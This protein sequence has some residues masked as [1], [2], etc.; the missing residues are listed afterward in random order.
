MHQQQFAIRKIA[1]ITGRIVGI[2]AILFITAT[3]VMESSR[4]QTFLTKRIIGI[5]EN[6]LDADISVRSVSIKPIKAFVIED[7]VVTDRHPW[8]DSTGNGYAPVDTILAADLIS[9]SFSIRSLFHH[10]G[11]DFSRV[12]I[13]GATFHMVSEPGEIWTGN[14]Q[15]ILRSKPAPE[16]PE[17]G[18]E[19]F[20]IRRLRG[21]DIRFR[22]T[23]M[24]PSGINSGTLGEWIN[25][26]CLDFRISKLEARKVGMRGGR[27]YIIT[28]SLSFSERSGYSAGNLSF[29]GHFGMGEMLFRNVHLTDLWSDV[30]VPEI[31]MSFSNSYS[32][33]D[34]NDKVHMSAHA[35]RTLLSC[36]TLSYFVPAVPY[37][38]AAADILSL[39][40]NGCVNDFTVD[41][42]KFKE[43]ASGTE[44]NLDSRIKNLT[45]P[46]EMFIDADI[47][48]I[49][50]STEGISSL[51]K[52]IS[53]ES[54]FDIG[55]FAPGEEMTFTGKGRG[56]VRKLQTEGTIA[57]RNGTFSTKLYLQNLLD[58]T[59][60]TELAG[61]VSTDDFDLGRILD[62]ELFAGLTSKAGIHASLVPGSPSASIDS[63]IIDKLGVKGYDYSGIKAKGTLKGKEFNGSVLCDDPN[64]KLLV[65]GDCD[66]IS[67]GN[68]RQYQLSANLFHANLKAMH[69]D[70]RDNL[71]STV[72]CV[73]AADYLTGGR[74]SGSG[75]AR[76]SDLVLNDGR[77]E[78]QIGDISVKAEFKDRSYGITMDSGFADARY[79]GTESIKSMI[80]DILAVTVGRHL[81]SLLPS[82]GFKDS[83]ET[84][85]YDIGIDFHDSR[86]LMAFLKPGLYIA[87]ST[88]V[89]LS[90]GDNG[91]LTASLY[92]PRLA[93]GKNYLK[94][95]GIRFDNGNGR[96]NAVLTNNE[97]KGVGA[98][99]R[100]SSTTVTAMDDSVSV[101][102]HLDGIGNDEEYG[103]F[104]ADGLFSRTDRDSL[105]IAVFPRKSQF[106][107]NGALWD[108]DDSRISILG[109]RIVVDNFKISSGNQRLHINGGIS[110]NYADTL[111]L[112][113]SSLR[114]GMAGALSGKEIELGGVAGGNATLV[115][116]L[117]DN[118]LISLDLACD[119]LSV[120][121]NDIGNISLSGDWDK[122]NDRIQ[123]D[124][125]DSKDGGFPLIAS[126]FYYPDTKDIDF[127]AQLR[128]FNLAFAEPFLSN[129]F[130][131]LRGNI[132]GRIDISGDLDSPMI[133]S[134]GLYL[135]SVFARIDITGAAY[136][137]DGPVSV[138]N[139]GIKFDEL[140]VRDEKNGTAALSGGI[141]YDTFKDNMLLDAGIRMKGLQVL[142][143]TASGS[144]GVYGSLAAS[145]NINVKGPFNDLGINGYVATSGEGRVHVPLNTAVASS[146]SD[147]LT[148]K[149]KEATVYI[150]PYDEMISNV[151]SLKKKGRS[152]GNVRIHL[153]AGA[154]PDVQAVL[155]LNKATGNVI[156]AGGNASVLLDME[157]ASGK[158]NVV[159]DYNISSGKLHFEVPGIARREFD[160]IDGSTIKLNGD[161]KD[162]EVNINASY[163]LKTSLSSILSD[164][165]S[166]ST[167]RLVVCSINMK[168]SLDNPEMT[169]GVDVPDLDPESRT[170]MAEAL[171]T[172]DKVQKQFIALLVMGSF[173]PN[174]MSGVV[175][176]TEI[177][178]SNVSEIMANQIN[179]IFQKLDIPLDLG[180]GYQ[181]NQG[182]TDIFDVAISTQLFNNR[183][184]IGG[185]VGN[186]QYRTSKNPNGDVVGDI[187]ISIKLDKPGMFK[188]NLF[189]HSADE[190][191]S[192]LDYSQ[193]NGVGINYSKEYNNFWQMLKEL[194]SPRRKGE[195][196]ASEREGGR[197]EKRVIKIE[198]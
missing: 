152:K 80:G 141:L 23:N 162:T 38:E 56:F 58:K 165:T 185:T 74:G 14:L 36:K 46:T 81:P 156:T 184:E 196:P 51:V 100:Q 18:P 131:E 5:L 170:K 198:K 109:K 189:S 194:F 144:N 76:I 132:S 82:S 3:M 69:I 15:R 115:S 61:T 149:E 52:A 129:L 88:K 96:L 25:W 174:E 139:E 130:D 26:N 182:G 45:D 50:F 98:K 11:M 191:T 113:I 85:K 176:G 97:I 19:I 40:M 72:S 73:I 126:G 47:R 175:K 92:S 6:S 2:L 41:N 154:T 65:L 24:I 99:I 153:M 166:V 77:A 122:A 136:T 108:V 120:D 39:E 49:G 111:N 135:N 119:S 181:P 160:I 180:L 37:C 128:D 193:R 86:N 1:D 197:R 163:K 125:R 157:T 43:T 32:L 114:L 123:I 103:D 55:R 94:G 7:L 161:P 146:S 22:R 28:D 10:Q 140:T 134:S 29:S 79:S 187:D 118:M 16:I 89:S 169:F 63:L 173:L 179:N 142:D 64:L 70:E 21:S 54:G 84:G 133:N 106:Y 44:L 34:F 53:P 91:D 116:P 13:N 147:L 102:L 112:D 124:I 188:L 195:Q 71:S 121:R 167:R 57:L 93:Y 48:R 75:T 127:S 110:P 60:A 137:L 17:A 42:V 177:L 172:S 35:G 67:G 8:Q 171:N 20:S 143:K 30:D 164:T 107:T 183:V 68:D 178:Y 190:Y 148:F 151:P 104:Y 117:G 105:S 168:G 186:R 101:R 83:G 4:V 138:D 87:D 9:G 155:E 62:N 150:D 78:R 27:F 95:A 12:E 33:R 192:F 31:L 66:V 59:K 159:G 158:V 90:L 145:G